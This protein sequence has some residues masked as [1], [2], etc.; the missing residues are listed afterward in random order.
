MPNILFIHE[1]FPAQFGGLAI[2]LA[3]RGWKVVFATASK[4]VAQDGSDHLLLPGVHV[5]G[6]RAARQQSGTT[7]SYLSGAEKAVLNAQGFARVGAALN[8]GGFT[9][10][11]IVAH[12]GWGSGSLARVIWPGVKF[13]Q[14]LEWWYNINGV[15]E[16]AEV[17]IGNKEDRAARTLCRNLPF[18]LDAQSADAI[19][20][21]TQFQAAQI[22]DFLHGQVTVLHDGVD[23]SFFRPKQPDD[24]AFEFGSLPVGAP[25][26]S[27]ATRGMEPMRGFP[28]FMAAWAQLQTEWPDLHCVIAGA[29]RTCYGAQPKDGQSHKETLLKSYKFD[30]TRLHFTG[31]LPKP[32]YKSLLQNTSAHVYLTR[33]FVLSWSL[34][35]AM[36]TGAAIV[37]SNTPPVQEVAPSSTVSYVEMDQPKQIAS[38]VSKMIKNPINARM[39]GA[40]ARRHV[41]ALYATNTLHPKHEQLLLGIIGDAAQAKSSI[42]KTSVNL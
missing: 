28:Q 8:K 12:S 13:V 26:V 34:I 32:K 40:N 29:D 27:Y 11:I 23:A 17:D 1:N 38:A 25:Y 41:K 4:H 16:I 3:R 7:H 31:L 19:W 15:D 22:P 20:V 36:M 2:H 14:Y 39:Q 24:A 18:L 42:P 10:D 37:A 6:Y 35:E 21:P 9:P 5:V 30:R 33:P